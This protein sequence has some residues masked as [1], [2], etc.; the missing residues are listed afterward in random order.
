MFNMEKFAKLISLKRRE[1]GL[2]QDQL[3]ELVGVTHQAVSKW[4]RA[5]AL[6]EISKIGDIAKAVDTPADELINSLYGAEQKESSPS[7]SGSADEAYF[8]LENK[9]SVGDIYALAPDLSE[10]TLHLAIDTLISAKGVGSASMLFKFVDKEYLSNLG[11]R[12]F[13]LG[14]TRLAEYVDESSLKSAIVNTIATA[15]LCSEWRERDSYYEKAG[16]MLVY[17]TDVDFINDMF[18]HMV[19]AIGTWNVWKKYIGRL[20]SEVVVAQGIKYMISH[21]TGSFNAWWHILGR[22]N[23]AKIFIGYADHFYNNHQAWKD[24]SHYYGFADNTIMESAIKERLSKGSIRGENLRPVINLLDDELKTLLNDMGIAPEK[25]SQE[26]RASDHLK[27]GL[28]YIKNAG[29]LTN[30]DMLVGILGRL[31]S[32]ESKIEEMSCMVDDMISTVDECNGRFDDI[33]S[34]LEEIINGTDDADE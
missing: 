11:K 26:K 31:E 15:D 23:T 9:T 7:H 17:C 4:E 28:T 19:S 13:A 14:D 16:T 33:E 3:A 24:I 12:L 21:G 22:R 6:P 25:S 10:E 5:E 1:K 27:Q 20:P 30:T 29:Y 32:I 8:A 18:E 34:Y 2:T